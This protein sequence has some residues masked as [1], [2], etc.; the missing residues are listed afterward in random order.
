MVTIILFSIGIMIT[1]KNHL[2]GLVMILERNIRF[3]MY[4]VWFI[5]KGNPAADGELFGT[6]LDKN[7][8]CDKL[9]L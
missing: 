3:I 2:K 6:T 4:I 1:P 7:I 8:K 5:R 9:K